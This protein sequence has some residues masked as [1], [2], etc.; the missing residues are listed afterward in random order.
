MQ[1]SG[2]MLDLSPHEID[3][4]VHPWRRYE[5]PADVV[6]D[7]TLTPTAR[8]A[9]LSAWA[10]DACAVPSSPPLRLAPFAAEPVTFDEV[11]DALRQMDQLERRDRESRPAS[12]GASGKPRG[13][14]S[15]AP[16]F[17]QR[18][19]SGSFLR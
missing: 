1:P 9:I 15:R 16:D 17:R 14:R 7:A 5:R 13:R 2:K 4:L 18:R 19:A 3:E 11:M 8:R 6:A 12:S 10:S